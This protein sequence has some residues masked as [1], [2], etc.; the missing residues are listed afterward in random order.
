VA[1]GRQSLKDRE[2][3]TVFTDLID[4]E[5]AVAKAKTLATNRVNFILGH[6]DPNDYDAF[7][8]YRLEGK[9]LVA[10]VK[11]LDSILETLD[12]RTKKLPGA[13]N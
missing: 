6:Q 2:P 11:E 5:R 7:E 1:D 4:L 8:K 12:K 3:F 10:I 9:N 13:C